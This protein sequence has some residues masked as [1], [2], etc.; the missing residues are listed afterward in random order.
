MSAMLTLLGAAPAQAC[1]K[2]IAG[3]HMLVHG[4]KAVITELSFAHK[5]THDV[6]RCAAV[7]GNKRVTRTNS[8]VIAFDA[9]RTGCR[10]HQ[11]V[12]VL[13]VWGPAV[14][15][16]PLD[17]QNGVDLLRVHVVG[18]I[19]QAVSERLVVVMW[20]VLAPAKAPCR[21]NVRGHA[22]RQSGRV[23]DIL[24]WPSCSSK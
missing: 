22:C 8:R 18:A 20:H 17:A 15:R 24:A 5:G 3:M 1:S 16:L 2:Y 23:C 21:A 14:Q 7:D 6:N 4:E 11:I 10:A 9:G 19:G 13:H 12:V